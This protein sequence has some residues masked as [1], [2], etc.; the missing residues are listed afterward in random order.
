M[1]TLDRPDPR[2]PEP[3]RRNARGRATAARIERVAVVLV[4]E[5]GLDA[6]T[7]DQVCAAAGVS[8][9]TFFHHFR[10]KEDAV[11]GT[12]LPRIDE[13]AARVWLADADAGV[14]SG[15]V[16]VI[17]VPDALEDPVA[18]AAQLRAL[19]ASPDLMR[20]QAQRM[21]PLQAE[22]HELIDLK[23][24][25]LGVAE[26]RRAELTAAVA[27]VAAAVLQ[28]GAV[29]VAH[30]RGTDPRAEALRSL[31]ALRELGGRLF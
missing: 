12:A 23:L 19:A 5:Q 3:K 26:P 21:Q 9:R 25:S 2:A 17:H 20:R 22:V 29:A 27:A 6:V 16:Q 15:L 4:D 13:R 24:A 31:D 28:Q 14:L 11:L 8:Q 7:V 18:H 30:G 10:T 1:T